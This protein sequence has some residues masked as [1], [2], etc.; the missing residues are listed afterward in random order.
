MK[1]PSLTPPQQAQAVPCSRLHLGRVG[2]KHLPYR[3]LLGVVLA[4][5]LATQPGGHEALA[6]TVPHALSQAVD[7]VGTGALPQNHG[8]SSLP[9]QPASDWF[10]QVVEFFS[11]GQPKS[12]PVPDQQPQKKCEN[13]NC[14]VSED[15]YDVHPVASNLLLSLMTFIAG[16]YIGSAGMASPPSSQ[17]RNGSQSGRASNVGNVS[18]GGRK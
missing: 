1:H 5:F 4:G 15:F 9:V 17:A 10:S 13:G 12:V 11:P 3:I 18:K 2:Q 14:G 16:W 8:A 6:A 7:D